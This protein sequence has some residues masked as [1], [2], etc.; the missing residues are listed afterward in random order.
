MY[1]DQ[2]NYKQLQSA[3]CLNNKKHINQL[4]LFICRMTILL[5][6]FIGN[7]SLKLRILIALEKLFIWLPSLLSWHTYNNIHSTIKIDKICIQTSNNNNNNHHHRHKNWMKS[8]KNLLIC[9]SIHD[10]SFHLERKKDGKLCHSSSS[11][12]WNFNYRFS[13]SFNWQSF[14]L[15][16]ERNMHWDK[17]TYFSKCC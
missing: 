17:N 6:S 13:I 7:S 15:T 9:I 12:C 14:L 2:S 10:F 5:V 3:F 8:H 1:S 16:Y 4:S 11:G